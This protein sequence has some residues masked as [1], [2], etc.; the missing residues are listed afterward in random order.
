MN[1]IYANANNLINLYCEIEIKNPDDDPRITKIFP[2]NY[3]DREVLNSIA[4]FA[5]PYNKKLERSV[6]L[7]VIM[8]ISIE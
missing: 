7:R 2:N 1:R 3:A 6:S 5:F 8:I 4:H